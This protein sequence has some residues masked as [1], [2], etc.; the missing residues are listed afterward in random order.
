L[1]R[2]IG[3]GHPDRDDAVRYV[4]VS[5]IEMDLH[6]HGRRRPLIPVTALITTSDLLL[7]QRDK[8]T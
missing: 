5:I 2:A 8:Y 6:S 1:G 7:P 4:M 3:D